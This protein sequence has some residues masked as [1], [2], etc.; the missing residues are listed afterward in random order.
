M[1]APQ[2]RA[3]PA[4]RPFATDPADH[5]ETP[6]LA[7]SHIAPLLRSLA[8]ALGKEPSKLRIWDPYYCAGSVIDRLGALGFGD[9]RNDNADFY[10][11]IAPEYDVLVTNPPFSGKIT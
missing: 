6:A 8:H 3:P 7:Y 11:R 4:S 2:P 10:T 5:C 9:V 1:A